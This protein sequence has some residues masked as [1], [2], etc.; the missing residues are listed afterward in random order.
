MKTIKYNIMS[1]FNITNVISDR[2][3]LYIN[4]T[5]IKEDILWFENGHKQHNS[6]MIDELVEDLEGYLDDYQDEGYQFSNR[7][8]DSALSEYEEILEDILILIDEADEKI[9]KELVSALDNVD[10]NAIEGCITKHLGNGV[11]QVSSENIRDVLQ[12]QNS[13]SKVAGTAMMQTIY[14]FIANNLANEDLSYSIKVNDEV[15]VKLFVRLE[16]ELDDVA[17]LRKG[18]DFRI[19][20]MFDA[21]DGNNVEYDYGESKEGHFY[22][23]PLNR[24]YNGN[25]FSYNASP[26]GAYAPGTVKHPTTDSMLEDDEY[27]SQIEELKKLVL[28]AL[29]NYQPEYDRGWKALLKRAENLNYYDINTA[30]IFYLKKIGNQFNDSYEETNKEALDKIMKLYEQCYKVPEEVFGN[31]FMYD[32]EYTYKEGY[33][34][35]AVGWTP[36]RIDEMNTKLGSLLNQINSIYDS[37][38]QREPKIVTFA[39]GKAFIYDLVFFRLTNRTK[40]KQYQEA[41]KALAPIIGHTMTVGDTLIVESSLKSRPDDS[42]VVY[43]KILGVEL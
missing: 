40:G 4:N 13:I 14:D 39:V 28:S 15:V 18:V 33:Y 23:P 25:A 37:L 27:R 12:S 26:G 1:V 24:V 9:C 19:F 38:K 34:F 32:V 16:N 29:N 10:E 42:D 17:Q 20:K 11:F 3:Q 8:I 6:K 21:F 30:L 7:D 43:G 5:K 41:E 2:Y 35:R 31:D 22:L 36:K